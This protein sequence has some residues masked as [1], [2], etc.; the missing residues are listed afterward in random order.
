MEPEVLTLEP[1]LIGPRLAWLGD[2]VVYRYGDAHVV[3]F[4]HFDWCRNAPNLVSFYSIEIAILKQAFGSAYLETKV[5][6]C[7]K[8][9]QVALVQPFIVGSPLTRTHVQN[10]EVGRQVRSIL[11]T[12]ESTQRSGEYLDFVG[13]GANF[14]R[15]SLGNVVVTPT[16][17]VVILDATILRTS[18]FHWWCRSIVWC[19]I[20]S[21]RVIQQMRTRSL[22][23]ST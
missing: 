14:F 11:S 7:S 1:S 2:H 16:N 23:E 3:K 17:Q 4:S 6:Y 15:A 21:G 5:G 10:P 19:V 13:G 22:L 9:N 8:R 20:H 18:D 12:L